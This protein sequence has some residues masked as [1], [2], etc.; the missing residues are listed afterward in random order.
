MTI[1]SKILLTNIGCYLL[2]YVWHRKYTAPMCISANTTWRLSNIISRYKLELLRNARHRVRD[3]P[4]NLPPPS[5]FSFQYSQVTSIFLILR[6]TSSVNIFSVAKKNFFL[7]FRV[8][9][10]DRCSK[11]TTESR[12]ESI[13]INTN[14]QKNRNQLNQSGS[15]KK[16]HHQRNVIP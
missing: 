15:C 12:V 3:F 6:R 11:R 1:I 10:L 13:F 2:P 8:Q 14:S 7:G 5:P 4:L 9:G 16:E